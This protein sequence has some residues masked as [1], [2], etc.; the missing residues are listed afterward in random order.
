MGHVID[1]SAIEF[2]IHKTERKAMDSLIEVQSRGTY[3]GKAK[4]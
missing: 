4:V 1:V 2:K 3:I